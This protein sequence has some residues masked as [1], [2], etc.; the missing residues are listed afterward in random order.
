MELTRPP[1][2]HA[3][4]SV[5]LLATNPEPIDRHIS[6]WL[7]FIDQAPAGSQLIVIADRTTKIPLLIPELRI[8]HHAQ[9][10]GLGASLQTAIWSV[11]TP[12]VL[13]VPSNGIPTP[14]QANDFL[15]RIDQADLVV[16][17]RWTKTLPPLVLAWDLL[18]TLMAIVFLGYV[19]E[20]RLGWPGWSGWGRRW[21][22]HHLFGVPVLDPE[23]GALLARREIF[24]R[25]PI[26]STGPFAWTELIAKAN[27]LGCLLDE[28]AIGFEPRAATD[29][30]RDAW[31]VFRRPEFGRP[32]S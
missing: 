16:G 13:F 11:E 20:P 5:V 24:D 3:P 29:F 17:C 22:A 30:K 21:I 1:I 31:R 27:H 12:L 19:P 15:E 18:R 23:S 7:W 2:R 6:S 28:A 8:I 32:S 25:I 9:P 4:L 26:Q 10:M 14:E